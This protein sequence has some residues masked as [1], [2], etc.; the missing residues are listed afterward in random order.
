MYAPE[1]KHAL[2]NTRLQYFIPKYEQTSTISGS[3]QTLSFC[4]NFED[5][6]LK[7]ADF[8]VIHHSTTLIGAG[9]GTMLLRKL[10][11]SDED[12]E[13]SDKVLMCSRAT[14]KQVT[15]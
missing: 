5:H 9:P 14:I 7:Q 4:I 10:E 1:S 12:S 2:K 3:K 13:Q 6:R 15:W 8:T 11:D